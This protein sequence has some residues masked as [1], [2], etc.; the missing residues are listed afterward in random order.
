MS[1][2]RKSSRTV[3]RGV[4]AASPPTRIRAELIGALTAGAVAITVGI[5]AG[6]ARATT[7]ASGGTVALEAL[8]RGLIVGVPLAVA[9]FA[10]SRP[11]HARFGR[12]L[13][14][15]S[16]LWWLASLSASS[17]PLL[18]S[19]G[20]VAGWLAELGLVYTLLAFPGGALRGRFDRG[21]VA[22]TGALV[23]TLYLP[24]SLLVA[25]YPQPSPWASCTVHC[26]HNA[27]MIVGSQPAFVN[28][29]VHVL[30]EAITVAV[31]LLVA[32]VLAGRIRDANPLM[33]RTLTPVLVAAIGRLIVFVVALLARRV[34]PGS[35]LTDVAVW[36]LAFALPAIA[37]AFLIGL[38][39]WYLF[40]AAGIR[41][42]NARLL[43]TTGPEQVQ[44]ILAEAFEDPGLQIASWSAARRSWIAP[45][46]NPLPQPAADSGRRLTEVRDGRRR[47]VAIL[48]DVALREDTAF[49]E[50]S[51]AAASVAFA[52]D[53]VASRTAGMV[54]ELRASRARILAA[55]DS[56]RRRIER[57][58]HDGAQQRLVALCIHLELAAEKAELD[59]PEE[60]A[61]LRELAMEVEQALDEI[62]S[63]THGIY[64]ATLLE[65]G[66]AAAVQSVAL[67]SP[68]PTSVEVDGLG[69]YPD[70]ISTAVYFCCVEAL[71][72][73]AK[74]A[75]G[76]GSAQ[77]VLRETE[78]ALCFSVSDDGPG[79]L[80]ADARVGAGM[81]NMR[82]RMTTVG[83]QL[84]VGSR[85]G[86]GT[87]V[88]GRVPLSAIAPADG[89]HRVPARRTSRPRRRRNHS[90]P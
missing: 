40:V 17:S 39:R 33:R 5:T 72:N 37:V 4:R 23:A 24:T 80:E 25:R 11:A 53:R 41:T 12:Q 34:A 88:S 51:A 16:G 58:L 68:V 62:R 71:Q 54:R 45:D 1:A 70:E 56:E 84:T 74:H 29:F 69:E 26:P 64:P 81:L 15:V 61:A 18:Y 44:E 13:L 46:G 83:G 2:G 90:A 21:L 77:I 79:M 87:R 89:A 32:G 42:V 43:R 31:F 8:A 76:A 27:F 78:S 57:D 35:P 66:L 10:C 82:D 30:R 7:G 60:A 63:L 73:V 67:R 28:G 85:D 52:S 48:H 6:S 9:L 3:A 65:Q 36:L 22:V 49:V 20:R 59:H 38:I 75:T 47:V 14:A 19:V 55:A 86:R 50:A